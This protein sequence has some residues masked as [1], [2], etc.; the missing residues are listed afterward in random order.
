MFRFDRRLKNNPLVKE[1]VEQ[2]WK[3]PRREEVTRKIARVRGAI[4][5]WNKEQQ[6][7]SRAIIDKR[8]EELEEA[9]VSPYNDGDRIARI[10]QELR[11]AYK[12]EE[13][14]W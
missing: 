14:Y 13:E 12:A 2:A 10:N 9:M 3:G 1:L 4:V 7:T 11:E 6:A 8:K 5:K